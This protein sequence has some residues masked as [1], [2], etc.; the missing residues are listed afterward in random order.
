MVTVNGHSDGRFVQLDAI[1]HVKTFQKMEMFRMSKS[2]PEMIGH[3]HII[4]ADVR[5]VNSQRHFDIDNPSTGRL[6][7]DSRSK[8]HGRNV[9][10]RKNKRKNEKGQINAKL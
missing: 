6:C 9:E 4:D 7:S 3:M 8:L 5:R 2:E 1:E 10:K